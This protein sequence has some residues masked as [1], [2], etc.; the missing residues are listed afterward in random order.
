MWRNDIKCKYMF[1]F[2]LK[3][4]ARKGLIRR[5]IFLP[6]ITWFSNKGGWDLTESHSTWSVDTKQAKSHNSLQPCHTIWGYGSGSTLAQVMACGTWQHQAITI[7]DMSLKITDIRLQPHLPG[8]NELTLNVLNFSEGTYT[9]IY[10]LC[11]FSTLIRR[12]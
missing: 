11:H 3:N 8:D 4:L 1:M 9:Y 2:P 5:N 7:L 6:I 12:R 10:I